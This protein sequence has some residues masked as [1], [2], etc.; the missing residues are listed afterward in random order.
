MPLMPIIGLPSALLPAARVLHDAP[1]TSPRAGPHHVEIAVR[2]APDAV[3][4]AKARIAPLGQ[5]LAF[6]RQDADQTA[7]VLGDIHAFVGVD[8][9]GRRPDQLGRPDLEELAVLVEDLH[10]VVLPVAHEHAPAPIDPD[11]MR[12]VELPGTGARLT[13]GEKIRAVRGELVHA[14]VAIPTR[15]ENS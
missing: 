4:R 10:A 14:R 5:T 3:T 2:V 13:P 12:Q 1:G 8:V 7:V 9:E 15:H 11:T 6:E